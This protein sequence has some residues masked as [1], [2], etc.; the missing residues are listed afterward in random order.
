MEKIGYTHLSSIKSALLLLLYFCISGFL[1]FASA[2][3][4][5]NNKTSSLLNKPDAIHTQQNAA[6]NSHE[7]F[8]IGLSYTALAEQ[9]A[10]IVLKANYAGITETSNPILHHFWNPA[11]AQEN[12]PSVSMDTG[13]SGYLSGFDFISR[14]TPP[15]GFVID[16]FTEWHHDRGS[17]KAALLQTTLTAVS[18]GVFRSQPSASRRFFNPTQ[19]DFQNRNFR[20]L[21][22]ER[23]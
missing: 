23:P 12:A 2:Q 5:G 22:A 21:P 9:Q 18:F 19:A 3:T 7:H 10:L 6:L 16:F 13:F 17:L 20:P 15:D 4:Q 11:I 14:N 8:E 1:S